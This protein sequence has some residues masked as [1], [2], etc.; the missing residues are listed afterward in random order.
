MKV[1]FEVLFGK[2]WKW[3]GDSRYRRSRLSHVLVTEQV[4]T[5]FVL[6]F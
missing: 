5:F 6:N 3:V 1:V 2:K 4:E